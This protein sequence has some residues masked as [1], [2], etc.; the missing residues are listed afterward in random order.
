MEVTRPVRP[1]PRPRGSH[2]HSQSDDEVL[3]ASSA[4]AHR[5]PPPSVH[6]L[7]TKVMARDPATRTGGA[8]DQNATRSRLVLHMTATDKCGYMFCA[9]AVL[10]LR[11]LH[12][13]A[14]TKVISASGMANQL[15]AQLMDT[16]HFIAHCRKP[17]WASSVVDPRELAWR[18]LMSPLPNRDEDTL[19]SHFFDKCIKFCAVNQERL[20]FRHRLHCNQI[21]NWMK[22]W[23]HALGEVMDLHYHLYHSRLG[24]RS[25]QDVWAWNQLSEWSNTHAEQALMPVLLFNAACREDEHALV[26]TTSPRDITGPN[27][28]LVVGTP[29]TT[30][31]L[32]HFLAPSLLDDQGQREIEHMIEDR[33]WHVRHSGVLDP[34]ASEAL[35]QTFLSERL[36]AFPS[37]RLRRMEQKEVDAGSKLV[38][39]DAYMNSHYYRRA[40]PNASKHKALRYIGGV[41]QR[42]HVG[43]QELRAYGGKIVSMYN[44]HERPLSM[45]AAG[46]KLNSWLRRV[47]DKGMGMVAHTKED[48]MQAANYGYTQTYFEFG[49]CV[50]GKRRYPLGV[51]CQEVD[52]GDFV[53]SAVFG[54]ESWKSIRQKARDRRAKLRV[55]KARQQSVEHPE[56]S[57]KADDPV[58]L[59]RLL[60]SSS[61]KQLRVA[62]SRSINLGDDDSDLDALLDPQHTRLDSERAGG[63]SRFVYPAADFDEDAILEFI[64]DEAERDQEP[65]PSRQSTVTAPNGDVATDVST[66]TE[67]H[68]P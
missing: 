10:A 63:P 26:L 53:C 2:S 38:L 8:T 31:D 17:D 19:T 35:Q 37:G 1:K 29:T 3:H 43:G 45:D 27:I 15:V 62:S 39:I 68:L 65:V 48:L 9:G 56:T 20:L 60:R 32:A 61:Q 21:C 50:P 34:Y 22:P 47:R 14:N 4:S 54:T 55:R 51:P 52:S 16:A 18:K 5:L 28:P 66:H 46:S 7:E 40:S 44:V 67:S 57:L 41:T 23:T 11:D 24:T 49:G 42:S 6:P 30:S 25:W 36:D 59:A 13:L 64:A 58:S 33:F 12:M